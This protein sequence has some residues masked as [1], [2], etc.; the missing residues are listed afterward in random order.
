MEGAGA[1]HGLPFH[2]SPGE[3]HAIALMVA[4]KLFFLKL[5]EKFLGSFIAVGHVLVFSADT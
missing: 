1:G 3:G 2:K 5:C 4:Y